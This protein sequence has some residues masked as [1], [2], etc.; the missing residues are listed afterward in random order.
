M[1][2]DPA[3]MP[4]E[5]QLDRLGGGKAATRR[6]GR[7][8]AQLAGRQHGVIARR[9][10]VALG[11]GTDAIDG[12]TAAGR[13]AIVHRGVYA[14]G[15]RLLTVEGRW[16]AAVLAGGAGAILS[17]TSAADLWDLTGLSRRFAHVTAPSRR[18]PR[19]GCLFHRAPLPNDEVTA[20]AG[21]PVTTV[22]R[23][24]LDAAATM[25]P[26]RLE[27]AISRAEHRGLADS[28]SLAQLI[29]RHPRRR[30]SLALR[31][32]LAD[33]RLGLDIA[34]GELEIGFLEF[35]ADRRLPPPEVNVALEAG[36]RHRVADCLWR[37]TNLVVEL[38]S[39]RHHSDATAF[40]GDRARDL[41]L[42]ATGF[43][44]V[45]VNWR[46]LQLEPDRL[47]AELRA[48]LTRRGAA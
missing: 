32:I 43:V 27:Q 35:V 33:N 7:A 19:G 25:T 40:E 47:E 1:L 10:L 2:D 38:D 42:L 28:P 45:R 26:I 12:W 14:V 16:M 24:L 39:R 13:L 15:H 29:V 37:E 22:A 21:I 18:T 36:G 4:D 46:R 34:D 5:E 11:I 48:V 23:T 20:R 17:H 31:A 8:V 9:Q 6:L 30:G 44:T 3:R 41:A